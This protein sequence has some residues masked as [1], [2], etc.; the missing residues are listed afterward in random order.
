MVMIINKISRFRIQNLQVLM[1]LLKTNIF[2]NLFK[3]G[4]HAVISFK[5]RNLPILPK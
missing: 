3:N 4:S 5:L 2:A 1:E